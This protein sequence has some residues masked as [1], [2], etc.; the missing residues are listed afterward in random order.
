MY[1]IVWEFEAQPSRSADFEREY[2]AEGVWVAFFRHG[3]GYLGTE[4][5]RSAVDSTRYLTLD[6]WVSRAAFDAFRSARHQE[7][8]ALDARCAA[9]T[10]AERLVAAGEEP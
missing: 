10:R 1:R 2:G 3:E 8:E 9:L 5:F 4:L 6:R 7:Y